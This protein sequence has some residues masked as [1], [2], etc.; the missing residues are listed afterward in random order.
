MPSRIARPDR[1]FAWFIGGSFVYALAGGFA[2]ALLLPLAE[3]IGWNLGVRWPALVQAHGHLQ[4]AGWVGLFIIGMVLRLAPRFAGRPLRFAALTPVILALMLFALLGRALAQPWLDQP[5]LYAVLVAAAVAELVAALFFAA[6]V[7]A[8]VVPAAR[9]LPVAPL[10][11]LGALGFLAQAVLGAIWLPALTPSLPL[12]APDRD[13]VLLRLQ[14]YGFLL[15]FVFAVAL[16]ALPSFFK[17]RLPRARELWLIAMLLAA[18]VALSAVALSLGASLAARLQAAG[19]LLVVAAVA[20]A[21][22]ETG[23]W[24]QPLGLR[25]SAR[26]AT[27]LVRTVCVWLLL[28]TALLAVD[29]VAALLQPES[30]A[31]I[32]AGAVRHML[33]L[34]V[35]STMIAGMAPLMLPWLAQRRQQG[36]RAARETYVLWSLFTAATILRVSGALIGG[37]RVST[38][39]IAV[40]GVLGISAVL[41]LGITVLRAARSVAPTV[42]APPAPNPPT[43]QPGQ[44]SGART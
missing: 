26:H 34:G 10:F 30:A 44:S 24:R 32:P 18:G 4:V 13:E 8:T 27:L 22:L 21:L 38:W 25:L 29:S 43:P 19:D 2:L 20:G 16:R 5:G 31:V 36:Y 33:A 1:T 15:P 14:F 35:F 39:V 11:L 41:V 12:V 6:A 37:S 40:S 42:P 9:T 7:V 28:A 3:L 17:H 23:V